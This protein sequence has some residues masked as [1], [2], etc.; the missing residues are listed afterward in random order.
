[1]ANSM[2]GGFAVASSAHR[3]P[4]KVG[5]LPHRDHGHAEQLFLKQRDTQSSFQ[6]QFERRMYEHLIGD[7]H[8]M[9]RVAR[10]RGS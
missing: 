4:R 9:S 3:R 1:M 2:N 5:G 6:Y 7:Y 8:T 10:Q